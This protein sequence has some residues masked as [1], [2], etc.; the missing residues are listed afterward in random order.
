MQ[1]TFFIIIAFGSGCGVEKIVYYIANHPITSLD[2]L[3]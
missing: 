1:D 3:P 2:T